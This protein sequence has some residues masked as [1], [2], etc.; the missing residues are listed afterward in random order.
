MLRVMDGVQPDRPP[1]GFSDTLWELLA[2]TWVVQ[3]AHEPPGRPPARTVL[4]K[5]K[6]CVDDWGKSIVPLVPEHWQ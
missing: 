3:H 1:S 6:E 5:L 4:G 2:S